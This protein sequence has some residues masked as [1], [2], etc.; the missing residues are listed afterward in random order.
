MSGSPPPTCR[1]GLRFG[2]PDCLEHEMNGVKQ[3]LQ[4]PDAHFFLSRTTHGSVLAHSGTLTH[5]ART[6]STPTRLSRGRLQPLIQVDT[7]APQS[8]SEVFHSPHHERSATPPLPFQNAN[9][10][11]PVRVV[12]SA[13][14]SNPS[15]TA[16]Q[17][18]PQTPT[19]SNRGRTPLRE[20]LA[21]PEKVGITM[22]KST[23]MYFSTED[24]NLLNEAHHLFGPRWEVIRTKYPP[25]A[26][27]TGM[28]LK[29]HQRHMS[30]RKTGRNR[31]TL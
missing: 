20:R 19:G 23:R 12:G 29:D 18:V 2:C 30:G 5:E 11:Q 17:Y 8:T 7:R 24:S 1:H 10:T 4:D 9:P 27:Y 3:L 21:S 6:V 28:Q 13:F 22:N 15:I 31:N 26:K 25:L 14:A 16:L